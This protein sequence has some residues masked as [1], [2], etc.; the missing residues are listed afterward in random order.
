MADILSGEENT[1]SE[2]IEK[3]SVSRIREKRGFHETGTEKP[4][5]GI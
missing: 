4:I 5:R 2:T 1:M 3:I